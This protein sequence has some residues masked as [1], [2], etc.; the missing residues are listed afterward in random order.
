MMVTGLLAMTSA[1]PAHAQ[2]K[3]AAPAKP[4]AP[5]GKGAAPAGK[6]P[7]GKAAPAK[8]AK[9]LTEKQK[10]EGA[11]KAYK[12]GEAKFKDGN[13]AAALELY[14]SADEMLPIPATKY[15][16][17]VCRDK[18]GQVVE[19]AGAYQVFLDS[20][21]DDKKMG[22]A[23]S[24]AKTRLDAIK[25]TPG[26]VYI[27]I[28]PTTVP[29]LTIAVDNG[30]PQLARVEK[31]DVP[32]PSAPPAPGQPPVAPTS[33]QGVSIA[34][35]PGHHKIT[36]AGEGFD[37]SSTELDLSFA[38]TRDVKLT[39]N[40]TPPPPPP[41][42]VAQN[43]EPVAPPPPPPPPPRSNVPAYVTLGLAGAGLVVGGVFGGLA[44]KSKSD[45]NKSPTTDNADKTD[46][47][48]LISDMSFAVALT[49]GVTGAVLLLSNDSPAPEQPKAGTAHAQKKSAVRGFVTPYFSP[50]G[51]GAAAFLTF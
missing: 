14:K 36:A 34:M 32:P 51:G 17:A 49:F 18:L 13:Y 35:A 48:A 41:P 16:I 38:E 21:P 40:P 7:A 37:P 23:I 15:K 12:E 24:D 6:A 44:L 1:T 43:P 4:A 11:R 27:A 10:K 45:F 30:Q 25:K 39:L 29:K 20:S 8:P 9:P 47:N 42:P 26:K 50:Q 22:D 31:I 28:E 19:A 5:A 33:I 2:G 46:R 3:K